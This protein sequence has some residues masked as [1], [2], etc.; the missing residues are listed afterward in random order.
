MLLLSRNHPLDRKKM[1]KESLDEV[2]EERFKLLYRAD[3]SS[4]YHRRR[5]SFLLRL[6]RLLTVIVLLGGAGAFLT[7]VDELNPAIGKLASLA[8]AA[9]S[10]LQIVFEFGLS[11]HRHSEWLG[12]WERLTTEIQN[13]EKPSAVMLKA[14]R[15]ERSA[16][17]TECVSELRALAIASENMSRAY[18]GID[19]G[20]RRIWGLQRLFIHFGTFQQNFPEV[21][22][23]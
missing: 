2:L 5:A 8:G 14:W 7:L 1:T 20:I 9:I 13:H 19:E 21:K 3:Y 22:P 6:D 10:M 11:G 12:R 23:G 16:I 15:A 4:R 18:F 17:E